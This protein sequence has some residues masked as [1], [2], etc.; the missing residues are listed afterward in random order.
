MAVRY[1]TRGAAPAAAGRPP[2]DAR[3][4]RHAA[5][6]PA[7]GR[8]GL[9]TPAALWPR[10]EILASWASVRL[11]AAREAGMSPADPVRGRPWKADGY[12]DR[13]TGPDAVRLRPWTP[14]RIDPQ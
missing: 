14:Q 11:S 8:T 7:A 2:P 4:V 1:A 5:T 13:A 10:A 3:S 9:T 12:T 6:V